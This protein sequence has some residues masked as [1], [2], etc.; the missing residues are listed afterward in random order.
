V[1]R[2]RLACRLRELRR[3]RSLSIRD[4]EEST[5]ISRAYLSQIEN[6]RLLAR[7]EWVARLEHVYGARQEAWYPPPPGAIVGAAILR[8]G[9]SS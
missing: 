9:A 5:G 1:P 6:G 8:D 3:A 2:V 4:V 7:D